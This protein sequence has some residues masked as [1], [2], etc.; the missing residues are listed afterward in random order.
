MV[1][2]PTQD[3]LALSSVHVAGIGTATTAL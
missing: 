3:V 1:Q 2:V